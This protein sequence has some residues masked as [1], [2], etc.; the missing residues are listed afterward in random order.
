MFRMSDLYKTVDYRLDKEETVFNNPE[1][2]GFVEVAMINA[3][4]VTAMTIQKE[5]VDYF[6]VGYTGIP[7]ELFGYDKIDRT[8]IEIPDTENL[9]L[10]YNKYQE[11]DYCT[12]KAN[13]DIKPFVDIAEKNIKLYSPCIVCRINKDKTFTS[14]TN[15]DYNKFIKY[16]VE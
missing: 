5:A 16:L 11:I 6:V 13:K 14:I 15:E 9:V 7:K 1:K 12:E 2:Y 4:G 10:V 8:I 3:D